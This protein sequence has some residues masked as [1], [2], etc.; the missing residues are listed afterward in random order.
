MGRVAV[1]TAVLSGGGGLCAGCSEADVA[2]PVLVPHMN[3][4]TPDTQTPLRRHCPAVYLAFLSVGP[5]ATLL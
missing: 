2:L 3:A 5:G 1:R 4:T